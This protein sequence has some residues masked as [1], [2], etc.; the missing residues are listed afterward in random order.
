MGSIHPH[1]ALNIAQWSV[2]LVCDLMEDAL[3]S[4]M[5]ALNVG[6]PALKTRRPYLYNIYHANS[7]FF[8]LFHSLFTFKCTKYL[9]SIRIKLAEF[10]KQQISRPKGASWKSLERVPS[11]NFPWVYKDCDQ[12]WTLPVFGA[13]KSEVFCWNS[14]HGVTL[15]SGLRVGRW[16][17]VFVR[18]YQWEEHNNNNKN[19]FYIFYNFIKCAI[20]VDRFSCQ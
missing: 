3:Y 8:S 18:P 19:L 4:R 12:V 11:S 15:P 13:A 6:R 9:Y 7:I 14:R 5:D 1:S 2:W 17:Y 16:V 20:L 10:F